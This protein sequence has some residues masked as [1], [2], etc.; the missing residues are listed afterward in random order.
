MGQ[1]SNIPPGAGND[2]HKVCSIVLF[3]AFHVP[4]FCRPVNA[5]LG[6]CLWN[7]YW[8]SKLASMKM[9]IDQTWVCTPSDVEYEL[10]FNYWFLVVYF[11]WQN[12]SYMYSYTGWKHQT[13]NS[14]L[15]VS[16]WLNSNLMQC[17]IPKQNGRLSQHLSPVGHQARVFS[18]ISIAWCDFE[19]LYS[20]LIRMVLCSPCS[21][22]NMGGERDYESRAQHNDPSLNSNLDH[23]IKSSALWGL[24]H[25][26]FH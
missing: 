9:M 8:Q 16:F 6:C 2:K 19:Y 18:L 10:C 26:S 12:E 11:Y 17:A 20:T 13:L 14:N 24:D 3:Y 4:V 15:W 7:I 23:L 5:C 22:I 1:K 25:H 21:F